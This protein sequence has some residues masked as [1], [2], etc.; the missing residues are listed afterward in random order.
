MSDLYI[1]P[2]NDGG[3]IIVV[4]TDAKTT[5]AIEVAV[6]LSLFA[7]QSWSDMSRETGERYTS[8]LPEIMRGRTVSNQTRLAVIEAARDALQWMITDNV[9]SAIDVD[10]TIA[11]ASRID[12]S[13]QISRP[14]G[15][16]DFAYAVNWDGQGAELLEATT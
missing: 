10:A 4:G 1:Q 8:R 5:T 2:G 14:D 12:L 13:I 9:A 3:E 16:A 15:D 7:E 11:S 6:W